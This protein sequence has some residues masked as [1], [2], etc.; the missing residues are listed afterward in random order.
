[1]GTIE[2]N[3]QLGYELIE[4]AKPFTIREFKKLMKIS[5]QQSEGQDAEQNIFDEIY[6]NTP[7]KNPEYLNYL[8][9]S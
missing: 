7:Q 5:S 6:P 9:K 3:G 1:M 8:N 4:D 2:P